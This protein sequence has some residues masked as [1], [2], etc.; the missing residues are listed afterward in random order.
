MTA[1]PR[2]QRR[3]SLAELL[4]DP[5]PTVVAI[6]RALARFSLEEKLAHAFPIAQLFVQHCTVKRPG[7]TDRKTGLPTW[8]LVEQ[9]PGS[10]YHSVWRHHGDEAAIEYE[11]GRAQMIKVMIAR[12]FMIWF[13]S[14]FD[15]P[16]DWYVPPKPREPAHGSGSPPRK[17]KL[18]DPRRL[19]PPARGSQIPTA[20]PDDHSPLV[21]DLVGLTVERG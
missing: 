4:A 8:Q 14:G 10:R 21:D 12:E 18:R 7:K 19:G 6:R 11:V 2:H 13:G 15:L 17:K 3:R 20:H 1:L 9:C 16:A 5:P